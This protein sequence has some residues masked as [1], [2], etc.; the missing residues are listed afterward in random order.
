MKCS[1]VLGGAV[2]MVQHAGDEVGRPAA[3]REAV[4]LDQLEH[5]ARIPDVAQIDRS[6]F[7]HRDQEGAEHA[8]EVTD[9]GG[10]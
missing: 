5:L 8:D 1:Q 2:G 3:D 6:A 9:R 7:Q 10:R 4:A